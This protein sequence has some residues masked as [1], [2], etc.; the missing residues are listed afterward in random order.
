MVLLH[1][2]PA[3]EETQA[4]GTNSYVIDPTM[5]ETQNLSNNLVLVTLLKRPAS[6]SNSPEDDEM[7][8]DDQT[9]EAISDPLII[10][11]VSEALRTCYTCQLSTSLTFKP[12]SMSMGQ[13]RESVSIGKQFATIAA[14]AYL[15]NQTV[16]DGQTITLTF[17]N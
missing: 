13:L 11:K 10:E 1:Q 15:Q 14:S 16:Q 6:S 9:H 12:N 4:A 5:E 2:G 17:A 8:D 3:S 7:A